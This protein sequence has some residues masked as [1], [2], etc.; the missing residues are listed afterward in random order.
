MTDSTRKLLIIDDDRVLRERLATAMTKRGFGNVQTADSFAQGEQK[1]KMAPTHALIDMRL[2]DGNGLDLVPILKE[3][4]PNVRAVMLTGYG[5]IASAVVAIKQGA[6][7]FLAKPA[8]PDEIEAALLTTK[9][10][11]LPPPPADPISADRARWEYIQRVYEQCNRNVSETA[12][13]L[14]MHRRTLQRILQK[15]APK[16]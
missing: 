5:N 9:V 11:S 2:E 1:A 14:K 13:R 15:H 6:V 10:G 8:D 4:N 12:R 3:Y 16:G 7:D